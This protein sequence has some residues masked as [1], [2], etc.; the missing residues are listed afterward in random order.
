MPKPFYLIP[1]HRLVQELRGLP[2]L[3]GSVVASMMRWD[4]GGEHEPVPAVLLRS[5]SGVHN[6]IV[7]LQDQ[8]DVLRKQQPRG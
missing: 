5:I 7:C 6:A 1:P 3:P 2:G 4:D 8:L